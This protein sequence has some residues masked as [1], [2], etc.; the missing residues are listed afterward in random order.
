MRQRRDGLG[1]EIGLDRTPRGLCRLASTTHHPSEVGLSSR[2]IEAGHALASQNSANKPQGWQNLAPILCSVLG[3]AG[4]AP[5]RVVT[6]LSC[7]AMS[8]IPIEVKAAATSAGR[9]A[10]RLRRRMASSRQLPAPRITAVWRKSASSWRRWQRIR[11]P[12][13]SCSRPA[14]IIC[15]A[16]QAGSPAD[17]ARLFRVI[18]HRGQ[19]HVA[20][21][22]RAGARR[23]GPAPS[24]DPNVVGQP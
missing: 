8:N 20:A 21:V 19:G 9:P 23:A 1:C 5:S 11:T 4:S 3:L 13:R 6:A 18:V 24:V 17:N 22:A 7:A 2:A 16:R 10:V 12:R 14:M 15:D